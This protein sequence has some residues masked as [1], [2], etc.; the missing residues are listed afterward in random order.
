MASLKRVERILTACLVLLKLHVLYDGWGRLQGFDGN[1]WLD[2]FRATHWFEPLPGPKALFASYHPPLSYLLCRLIFAAYPHEVEASQILSTLAMLVAVFALRSTLRTIGLL[3]TLPG[4]SV[5]YVASSIPLTVWL[6]IETSYDPL[7][8]MWFMVA[9]AISARLFWRPTPTAWWRKP[10]YVAALAALGAALAG[11]LLTKFTASLALGIPFLVM[12][13]RRGFRSFPRECGAP[14][15]AVVVGILL[16]SPLYYVRYYRPLGQIFPQAMDWLRAD[17]LKHALRLRDAHRWASLVHMIRVPKEAI[18]GTQE[19]VRDSFIHSIWLQT[20][21]RD[22]GLGAQAPLSLAVSDLY[23]RVSPLIVLAS[24]ALFAVRRHKLPVALR[25][26]GCVLAAV[27]VGFCLALLR[28]GWMYPLW[29]WEVFKAKY[30]A[31]AVLWIPYCIALLVERTSNS[32]DS[33]PR[34]SRFKTDAVLLV[35]ILFMF[36]NHLLPVY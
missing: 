33:G 6:S 30:I 21:K 24:T 2:V 27:S 34:W 22:V 32:P 23:V 14:V 35:L 20:W 19:P 3:W 1:P 7:V 18:T 15:I 17:D 11:G 10:V 25:D 26:L 4:L 8:F 16:V 13:V 31:P 5:L 29:D 28:F 9:L 12:F 36:T